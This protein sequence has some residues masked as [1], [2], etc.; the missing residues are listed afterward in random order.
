M[1]S[2]VDDDY[3]ADYTTSS[4][5][6]TNDQLQLYEAVRY[7]VNHVVIPAVLTFGAVG[8]VV[9][10][11][12]LAVARQQR[13]CRDVRPSSVSQR[14]GTTVTAH[15]R[16][17]TAWTHRSSERSSLV[18]LTALSISDLMFCLVGI[19]AALLAIPGA[20]GA[21]ARLYNSVCRVPLHNVFLFSSTWIAALVAA[22]RFFV[23]V[24]PLRARMC[25]KVSCHDD[26]FN[27]RLHCEPKNIPLYVRSE[28]VSSTNVTDFQKSFT[29]RVSKKFATK[30]QYILPHVILHH[31]HRRCS[32]WLSHSLYES[33]NHCTVFH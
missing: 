24:S 20:G 15:G 26:R 18:G 29:A 16:D 12:R 6:V 3:F 13:L 32:A 10:L 8:N 27:S 31:R 22:E 4:S 7:Y 2:T 14:A 30:S 33:Q 9:V 1:Y 17:V 19:P 11:R 5:V 23:V 25:L 21:P 28:V